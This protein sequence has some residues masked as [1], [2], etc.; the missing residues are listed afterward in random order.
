MVCLVVPTA[1]EPKNMTHE[2]GVWGY[3]KNET[4]TYGGMEFVRPKRITAEPV[5]AGTA[6]W[7]ICPSTPREDAAIEWENGT[8]GR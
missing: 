5:P 8:K 3:L 7:Y 2:N 6:F 4:Y 1:A